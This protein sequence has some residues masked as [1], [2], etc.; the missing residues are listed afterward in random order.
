MKTEFA[1][2]EKIAEIRSIVDRM[3]KGI[4]DF[5]SQK[6]LF[7]QGSDLIKEC[8]EYLERSEME[9]RMLV[10]GKEEDFEE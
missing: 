3:Q 1:L 10:N 9:I 8:R 5:D 2:E 4:S 6:K 7:R